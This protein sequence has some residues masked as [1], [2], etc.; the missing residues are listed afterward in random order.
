MNVFDYIQ[1]YADAHGISDYSVKSKI[2]TLDDFATVQTFAPGVAFVHKIA[3]TGEI[4][5]VDDLNKQF[6]TAAT[7]SDYYDFGKIG[8]ISDFGSM[9]KNESDFVFDC[10]NRLTLDLKSGANAMFAKI[11][12]AQLHYIYM[13]PT[14]K[15]TQTTTTTS[16]GS[17]P[18]EVF[19][20][21][22]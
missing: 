19:I 22:A 15:S 2:L 3:V 7:N 10:D 21:K 13:L 5:T 14:R 17:E 20:K 9:Q 6:L 16:T 11:F 1:A 4:N 18:V 8:V 12:S